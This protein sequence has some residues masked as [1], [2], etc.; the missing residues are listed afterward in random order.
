MSSKGFFWPSIQP[1]RMDS[2]MQSFH[3]TDATPASDLK[4]RTQSSVA[5]PWCFSSQSA[6]LDAFLNASGACCFFRTLGT[7]TTW[8]AIGG[9]R[10]STKIMGTRL[11]PHQIKRRAQRQQE[12]RL[13]RPVDFSGHAEQPVIVVVHAVEVETHDGAGEGFDLGEA[14]DVGA[15][16]RLEA[17]A[18]GELPVALSLIIGAEIS[19]HGGIH[20][21]DISVDRNRG[22]LHAAEQPARLVLVQ[23]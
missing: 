11:V 19:N 20:L 3:V 16:E 14:G 2:I 9:K 21:G 6:S 18:A 22:H 4:I 10:T 5:V 13:R 17:G 12:G 8:A 15:A 23:R 7:A 1:T